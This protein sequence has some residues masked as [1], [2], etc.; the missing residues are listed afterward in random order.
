MADHSAAPEKDPGQPEAV[1]PGP[2]FWN[3]RRLV[4]LLALVVSLTLDLFFFT[5]FYGSDDISYFGYAINLLRDGGFTV[6]PSNGRLTVLGWN[7]LVILLAGWNGQAVAASYVLFHQLLNL[8]TYVLAR[9]L[10]GDRV[11]LVALFG[12]VTMPLL[13]VFSTCILPDLPMACCF[14]LA[15][16][17]FLRGLDAR[18]S[19]RGGSACRW[20]LLA[21]IAVG[22]GYMAKETSLILLPFFLG[23]WIS[24]EWR[25]PRKAA[26]L[27]GAMF[28]IGFFG[29]MTVETA[30]LSWINGGFHLRMTWAVEEMD[31]GD[32]NHIA[33][34]GTDPVK[35]LHSVHGYLNDYF[36]VQE[37]KPVVIA[38]FIV[39][40]FLYRRQW[41][42]YAL[43]LWA[44]VYLTWGS[45]RVSEY[46]PPSIQARYFIPVVP[47]AMIVSAAVLVRI[48][49]AVRSLAVRA[50][51]GLAVQF[52][53]VFLLGAYAVLGLRGPDQV[54][55]KLYGG[56][57]VTNTVMAVRRALD[58]DDRPVVLGPVV[59]ERTYR[60]LQRGQLPGVKVWLELAH[61]DG[62]A[63]VARCGGWHFVL[64]DPD[65]AH[66]PS[67]YDPLQWPMAWIVRDIPP[68]ASAD[69]SW[70][71]IRTV[72]SLDPMVEDAVEYSGYSLYVRRIARIRQP[73][74]HTARFAAEHLSMLNNWRMEI[75]P[76][77]GARG[78][79][80]LDV[81]ARKLHA[82]EYDENNKVADAPPA[83]AEGV[84]NLAVAIG[85]G[86]ATRQA[87]A[88]R[89]Q[90]TQTGGPRISFK[91][92]RRDFSLFE[93]PPG[94][95]SG[96]FEIPRRTRCDLDV[97]FEL[98]ALSHNT[99]VELRMEFYADPKWQTRIAERRF[100]LQPGV[101]LAGV[102]T[103]D[104]KVYL[105]PI[106]RMEGRGRCV[107]DKFSMRLR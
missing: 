3:V 102:R 65:P 100:T 67:T 73:Y 52:A 83:S 106:L 50:G 56:D 5:G 89:I 43:G 86:Q 98:T 8:S 36:M 97:Q 93:P 39:Y 78:V 66:E 49:D 79:L 17:A 74:T 29:V 19:D 77:P 60:L 2:G 71:Q 31:S 13:I 63:Q 107:I 48:Y 15:L 82:D 41:A 62:L 103:G 61:P 42:V 99:R 104:Q 46:F 4:I 96:W 47:L 92:P 88:L 57:D 1:A 34:H 22:F 16:H 14:V 26:V 101:N 90:R 81:A 53:A 20:L 35:R 25:S 12:T 27:R 38:C 21:G 11:A 51:G 72:W 28:A 23:L 59:S 85:Q 91:V 80:L 33:K 32:R 44:F 75:D 94:L 54:A 105:R 58:E 9:R 69:S 6:T 64:V 55:G 18:S 87:E 45:M 37:S 30:A 40:P 7:T 84:R 10:F 24:Q 68:E 70:S 76:Y 95:D